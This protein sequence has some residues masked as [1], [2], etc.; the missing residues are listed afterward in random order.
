[1]GA[2]SP[3]PRRVVRFGVFELNLQSGELRRSGFRVNLQDQPL[4]ILE[5]LLER[6]GILV[7][8]EELR[9]RLWGDDTFV[10]FE[11]GVNA[12]VK[13]LREALGDSAER[14]RFVE[15]LPKRGYRFIASVEPADGAPPD[16][17]SSSAG[18]IQ[19][20]SDERNQLETNQR[21]RVSAPPWLRGLI[22]VGGVILVV[23][24]MAAWLRRSPVATAAPLHVV[25]LT[26]LTGS[27][28]GPSFSPDARQV[29]FVWDGEQQEN[30]DIYVKLVGSPEVRRLTHDAAS[31]FAPQWSPD[32]TSIAYLRAESPRSHRIRLMSSLGGADR[33]LSQFPARPPATWSPDGKHLVAGAALTEGTGQNTGIYLIPVATGDPRTITRA[34]PPAS[35]GWPTFSPDG[36]HVAYAAC[37]ELQ[38]QSNCH[39]EIVDLDGA[40]TPTGSRRLTQTPVWTVEGVAWTRDG[41]SVIYAA[42]E[43]ALF[44]LWRVGVH[45]EHAPVRIEVA[46]IEAVSPATAWSTDRLAFSKSVDDEDIYRFEIGGGA[47]PIARS[48]VKDTNAQ[49]SPDGRRI[50]FCSARSGDAIELW[51]ADA[52]GA[53]PERLTRGPG[54]WQCSPSWSPDSHR[55]AFDSR[56]A[57]G[58]WH[59]WTIDA[60]GGTPQPVTTAIG[61]QVR[62]TWSRDGQWIYFTW[63]QGTAKDIWRTRGPNQPFERVTSGGGGG[64]R[65]WESTDGTGVFYQRTEGDSPLYFQPLVGGA[66]RQQIACVTGS[67]F[68]VG[69]QG[70]YYVPCQTVGSLDRHIPV[71]LLNLATGQDRPFALLDD[72]VFPAWGLRNGC[73]D[74]SRDGRTIV[75]SRLVNRGADL[76]L[77]ENF[78]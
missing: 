5:C 62:P 31:D 59:I 24:T 11:H 20:A 27:E 36:R 49:F 17:Y 12:A 42:R 26:T 71:R 51:V 44:H 63:K 66:P 48:T 53:R 45:G 16:F 47:R 6:P 4:K 73:F 65:A 78:K 19:G 55:I 69:P 28:Y 57:D 22:A 56:A 60:D 43:G 33:V 77:I 14:P 21:H 39:V 75:Y 38:Y 74:V 37:R 64:G 25:S 30:S 10:D 2:T 13:R 1:M 34:V 18:D 52:D 72:V 9:Q 76:M 40:G 67:R 35:H 32:G 50:V 41:S 58:S 70:I 54:L 3:Q 15:T 29:A 23:A 68:S 46:G 8:R 61:D 7:S